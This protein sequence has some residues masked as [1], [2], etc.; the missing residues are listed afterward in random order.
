MI[1]SSLLESI[2]PTQMGSNGSSQ[3]LTSPLAEIINQAGST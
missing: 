1:R 2:N 3:S